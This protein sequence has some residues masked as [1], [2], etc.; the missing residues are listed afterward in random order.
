MR[1]PACDVQVMQ[2]GQAD[3]MTPHDSTAAAASASLAAS[4]SRMAAALERMAEVAQEYRRQHVETQRDLRRILARLDADSLST[5][6][7]TQLPGEPQSGST[8]GA[9]RT[10]G[11]TTGR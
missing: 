11:G 6:S 9:G 7:P 4:V 5:G 3:R 10:A 8:P 1:R 2:P